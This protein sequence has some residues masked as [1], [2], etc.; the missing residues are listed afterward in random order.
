MELV[1]GRK[2]IFG[3][4]QIY[5]VLSSDTQHV[6]ICLLIHLTVHFKNKLYSVEQQ[7]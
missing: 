4:V 3:F 6:K 5:T 2:F 1:T 7:T